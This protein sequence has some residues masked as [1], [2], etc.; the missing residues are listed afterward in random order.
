MTSHE[1]DVMD[2]LHEDPQVLVKEGFVNKEDCEHFINI[3]KDKLKDA[4]KTAVKK[5]GARAVKT[6]L[7]KALFG[8]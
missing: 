1:E 3:C 4:A 8:I 7:R 5:A 2:V 6:G